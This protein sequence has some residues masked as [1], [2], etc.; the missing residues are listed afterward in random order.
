MYFYPFM[1]NTSSLFRVLF[2]LLTLSLGLSAQKIQVG[3]YSLRVNGT[4]REK[5]QW[6]PSEITY[7]VANDSLV[8]QVTE[9]QWDEKTKIATAQGGEI[10]GGKIGHK[11][12]LLKFD[13][14]RFEPANGTLSFPSADWIENEQV[15]NGE[16]T[17]TLRRKDP[18]FPFEFRATQQITLKGEAWEAE[19]APFYKDLRKGLRAAAL[20][21]GTLGT[22]SAPLIWFLPDSSIVV[23]AGRWTSTLQATDSL[24]RGELTGQWYPKNQTFQFKKL[25]GATNRSL[26][27]DTYHQMRM[28]VDL[29][30]LRVKE[31]RIDFYQISGRNQV[32]AW[33][34]SKDYYNDGRIQELQ[35]LLTYSPMRILYR[36]LAENKVE[37]ATLGDLAAL[38][39]RRPEQIQSGF[40]SYVDAGYMKVDE[41]GFSFSSQ[42]RHYARVAY[43]NKDFDTFYAAS[44][45]AHLAAD[46]ASISLDLV[47]KKLRIRGVQQVM[48]SDSL[49][50]EFIPY[51]EAL[52]F[53]KGRDFNFN[54]EI[55]VGDYRF[56][57]PDFAFKFNDFTAQFSKIDSITFIPQGQSKEF[58]GQFR[59]ESGSLLL[60]A[61]GNKSGRFGVAEYPKLIIP[62]GMTAHFD[63]SWRAKG[64]YDT[65]HYF[66]VPSIALDSLTRKSPVFVGT[67]YSPGLLPPLST[68][69]I[70]KPDQSFGF[71]Y[72]QKTPLKIYQ[73]KAYLSLSAPLEMDKKG[74]HAAGSFAMEGFQSTMKEVFLYPDSLISS[75]LEGKLGEMAN[76]K[77]PIALLPAHRFTW[78]PRED[79]LAIY[80]EKNSFALYANQLQLEGPVWMHKKQV[81]GKGEITLGDGKLASE[82]FY[83]QPATWKS[84]DASLTIGLKKSVFQAERIAIEAA[85]GAV[86]LTFKPVDE[87]PALLPIQGYKTA[88]TGAV[89]EQKN[90]KI[91]LTKPELSSLD[92]AS[93]APPILAKSGILDQVS[94]VLSLEGVKEIEIGPATVY[95]AKGLL[96]IAKGGQFKSL[97]GARATVNGHV[98]ANINTLTANAQKFTGTANYLLPVVGSDSLVIPMKNFDFLPEGIRAEARYIEKTPLKLTSHQEFKGDVFF[99][100]EKPS[101]EFKGSI[102][103][104]LGTLKFKTAWIPFANSKGIVVNDALKD[105][106]GR[107]VTAGIFVNADNK[108]YPSFLGP[109]SNEDD[110]VLFK[111]AG[112]VTEASEVYS[113]KNAESQMHLSIPKKRVDT[114]GMVQLFTGNRLVRSFG[115]ISMSLD[116]LIPRIESWLSLQ[117]QVPVPI[118]QKM[119]DRIVRYN[120]DEGVQTAA[121]D[122]PADRDDYLKRVEPIL[123]KKIPEATKARM[124]REHLALDKVDPDFASML[125][126]SSVKWAWSPNLSAFYSIGDLPLINVGPVDVNA[127]VKGMMEVIK[128]PTKEEFY[129]YWELSEDLWYYFAYFEGELGVYSSDNSFLATV[130]ES[131]KTQKK[132]GIKVVE[133]AAEE[134]A[135]FLKRFTSYYKPLIPVKKAPVKKEPTKTKPATKG[136][137]KNGGF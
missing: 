105:E 106:L 119:G 123:G 95:P 86:L 63:E 118:L 15:T 92:S 3:P 62:K 59:Y 117:F 58:G 136:K 45:G 133:A 27:E 71:T 114:D 4:Q 50:A 79:S 44:M 116:T 25:A 29:G 126:F 36:Y 122:E 31:K 96:A 52:I 9:F 76:K 53:Q 57:G 80:P 131:M 83:F 30:V 11:N 77:G 107:S 48:I 26:F 28:S 19:G 39:N 81:F 90:Q 13:A 40:Q 99:L 75:G 103:P 66:K 38:V 7:R 85:P 78:L 65:T 100:S 134:K 2:F 42:G 21:F 130:R 112:E 82:L 104:L 43:E 47:D 6:G 51:D 10:P 102:R 111:A 73:N 98:L 17:L 113:I 55:K 16:G 127:T 23:P 135:A 20:R 115:K 87:S 110:P 125:N 22:M 74:L 88:Y 12:A 108:L 121:A 24:T 34:E 137:E 18:H 129:A 120:L 70:L 109:M 8:F 97:T 1:Q 60:S 84:K 132:G 93:K 94:E 46:S 56:R 69:L 41:A 128:K 5:N 61:P 14:L 91:K 124:D 72:T 35:G 67:F 64:V 32:P 54:G 37:A 89:W 33:L 49:K 68:Q 101:L